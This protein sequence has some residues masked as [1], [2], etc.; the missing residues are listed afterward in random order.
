MLEVNTQDLEGSAASD[1]VELLA[2]IDRLLP[3]AGVVV[4][5]YAEGY[6]FLNHLRRYTP[7]PIRVIVWIST[8]VQFMQ[9]AVLEGFGR[10]LFTDVTIYVAP[11]PKETLVAALGALPEGLFR[12]SPGHDLLTLD[13]LCPK[14]PLD[15]LFH[16]FRAARRIVPLEEMQ[17][18]A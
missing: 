11:M 17:A 5:D 14:S 7:A 3:L 2:L 4:T 10:L 12:A 6:Q 8:F 13:D 18:K 15:H 16:Y 1:N 9:G